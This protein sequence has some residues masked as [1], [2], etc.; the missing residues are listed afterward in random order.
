MQLCIELSDALKL[1]RLLTVRRD[2]PHAQQSQKDATAEHRLTEEVHVGF[3]ILSLSI[4]I[5]I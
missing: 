4:Y 1:L 3:R 5:Y 2:E